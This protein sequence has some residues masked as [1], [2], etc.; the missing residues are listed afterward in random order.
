MADQ[1]ITLTLPDD[2]YQRFQQHAVRNHQRLEEDVLSLATNALTE[3]ELP[4]DMQQAVARLSQLDTPALWQAAR[5]QLTPKQS[6]TL[7]VLLS[8]QQRE[9]LTPAEKAQLEQVRHAHDL[10]LLVRA[11]AMGLLEERGEDIGP[12]LARG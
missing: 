3:D 6:K 5:R 10:I 7:E 12:L 11:S 4:A 1:T 2:L 9:G 8:K